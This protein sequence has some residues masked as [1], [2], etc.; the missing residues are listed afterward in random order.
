MPIF[1]RQNPLVKR[2]RQVREGMDRRSLFLEGVRLIEDAAQS[3]IE[4]ESVIVV[5][6]LLTRPHVAKLM[7]QLTRRGVRCEVTSWEILTCLSDVET[8]QGI[9]AIA[10]RRGQELEDVLGQIEGTALI[11]V[12]EGWRD[13]GNLGT[14]LRSAEALGVHAVVT[15]P[16]TVDPFSPKVLRA[17]MGSAL[18]VPIIEQVKLA[19]AL[20]LF[21]DRGLQIVATTA[22][23]D[24]ILPEVDF[25][26][27]TAVLIGNEAVGLSEKALSLAT[28]A[29]RIPMRSSVESLNAAMAATIILYEAARQR[30]FDDGA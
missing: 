30:G 29:V 25:I 8:P 14:M 19:S 24:Q 26:L 23:A 7:D 20:T 22:R 17:S 2:Y 3:G 15:T 28:A 16:Q 18:R 1:S 6:D 21:R 5:R 4:L 10:H 12:A 9:L 27:S 13:P 11:V